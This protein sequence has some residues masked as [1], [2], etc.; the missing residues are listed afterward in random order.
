[1]SVAGTTFEIAGVK[2]A[3]DLL[4]QPDFAERFLEE[5]IAPYGLELWPSARMLAER[6][7]RDEPGDGRT[8]I[9]L[10]CGLGLAS[11]AAA[12]RGW[13]VVATDNELTSL[14]FAE[15]NAAKNDAKVDGF[16]LLDWRHPLQRRRFDR[17]FAADVLYQLVDHSPLLRC[18]EQLLAPEGV[19][20]LADPNRGV[21]DRLPALAQEHGFAVDVQ[22]TSAVGCGEKTVPGRVFTLR[23]DSAL[24]LPTK[25]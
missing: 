4:D 12:I 13:R 24:N 8:A 2:D 25:P 22:P 9:E 6:I 7:L 17:V 23:R 18:I 3:A 11:I 15:L 20:I 16:E 14:R 19:A 5:D 10:G 1:V 21:A